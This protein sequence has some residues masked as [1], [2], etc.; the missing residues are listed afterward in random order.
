[1]TVLEDRLGC[2]P[3]A[4][5]HTTTAATTTAATAAAAHASRSSSNI[6]AVGAPT[7]HL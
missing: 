3:T 2:T 4:T 1:M 7:R 5:P 6:S